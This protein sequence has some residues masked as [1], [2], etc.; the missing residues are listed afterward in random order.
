MFLESGTAYELDLKA[1]KNLFQLYHTT[2]C[3]LDES[4]DRAAISGLFLKEDK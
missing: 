1:L 2:W 4:S 3:H